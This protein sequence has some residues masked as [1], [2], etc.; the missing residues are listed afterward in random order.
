MPPCVRAELEAGRMMVSRIK[1]WW[2]RFYI[3]HLTVC[4][5]CENYRINCIGV[6][7]DA[8]IRGGLR[9]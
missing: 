1:A 6:C 8:E 4:R 9:P 2:E 3:R 5:G 7:A